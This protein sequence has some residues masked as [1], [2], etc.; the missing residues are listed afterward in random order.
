M[1]GPKGLV[2]HANILIR[3]AFGRRVQEILEFY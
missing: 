3:A 1:N 2:L